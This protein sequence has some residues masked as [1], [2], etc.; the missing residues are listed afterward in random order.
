MH[1]VH[2]LV[3]V[4][5]CFNSPFNILVDPEEENEDYKI[6]YYISDNQPLIDF[7]QS[8]RSDIPVGLRLV[9]MGTVGESVLNDQGVL[10][11]F[12][13][14]DEIIVAEEGMGCPP[15]MA[16]T[17]ATMA[18]TMFSTVTGTMNA[19]YMG[20]MMGTANVTIVSETDEE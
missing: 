12:M 2:C 14:S 6:G 18:P 11:H 10:Q 16:A 7:A 5:P 4:P 15:E 8:V 17:E 20:T 13:T 3:D 19:T 1:S 9:V